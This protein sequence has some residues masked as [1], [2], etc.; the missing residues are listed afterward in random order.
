MIYYGIP[1]LIDRRADLPTNAKGG[2]RQTL[3]MGTKRGIVFHYNGPPVPQRRPDWD[4]VVFDAQYHAFIKDWSPQTGIQHGDGLMYHMA[5]ARDG[6]AWLTRSFEDVLWHCGTSKNRTALACYV[7]MGGMQRATGAQIATCARLSQEAM[8]VFGWSRRDITGHLEESSTDCPGTLMGDF[9]LPF[10][11]GVVRP[12]E[13]E[14]NVA[15]GQWF[16]ATGHY[17]GGGFYDFWMTRGGLA[18]FGYPISDEFDQA[19]AAAPG[20]KR[21][22]QAFERAVF[23]YHPED[24]SQPI[25]LRLVGND[26]VAA[27]IITP[28]VS[29]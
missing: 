27:G 23:E 14:D 8:R 25:K 22:V 10:R 11:A 15:D 6:T 28:P 29:A 16:E 18:I 24:P 20:G 17:V 26:V 13:P 19:D 9:V 1:N 5:V 3:P 21:T 4:Q 7:N 2:P 12:G